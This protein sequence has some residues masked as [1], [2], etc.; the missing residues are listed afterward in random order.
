MAA[1]AFSSASRRRVA[2]AASILRDNAGTASST[3][4]NWR[5]PRTSN[6][7]SVSDVTVAERGR[8]SS[9]AI[10][11]K[12]WPGPSVATLRLLRRTAASPLTMRKNSRPMVP[13]SHS[14]RPGGTVTSSSA[15]LIVR[16][17]LADEVEKSQI[18]DRSNLSPLM[19]QTVPLTPPTC[20]FVSPEAGSDG[21]GP[22]FA[23]THPHHGLGRHD[24]HLAVA[25][26]AGDG[27]GDDRV[28]HGL[29]AVVLHED[30][31]PEFGHEVD[32]VL[33]PPVVLGVPPLAPE[34]LGFGEGHP[35]HAHVLQHVLDVVDLERLDDR[36]HE[37]H[38]LYLTISRTSAPSTSTLVT[39]A[40]RPPPRLPGPHLAASRRP[41]WTHSDV[42]AAAGPKG[43]TPRER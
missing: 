22:A 40:G 14:M 32:L 35:C 27:G 21:V 29:G 26:L 10:S 18:L 24:P 34:P 15:R 25:D 3:P 16:R 31:E 8:R 37:L 41:A 13:C 42:S 5:W 17:S 1:I 30:L 4:L 7:M 9:S 36:Y 20:S 43:A 19:A 28:D 23:G 6:V 11:P 38:L 12:Y 2:M 33:G 39:W